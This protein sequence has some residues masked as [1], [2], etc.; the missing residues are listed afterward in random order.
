MTLYGKQ[1]E[2]TPECISD[3]GAQRGGGRQ[4]TRSA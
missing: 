2:R 1:A 3:A 4:A